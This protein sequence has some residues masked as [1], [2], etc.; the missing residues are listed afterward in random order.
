MPTKIIHRKPTSKCS[1]L[2]VKEIK[3]SIAVINVGVSSD[4]LLR[5]TFCSSRRREFSDMHTPASD[6]SQG[7]VHA[8]VAWAE[9]LAVF[10]RAW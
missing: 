1:V 5:D 7:Q 9:L 8:H 4:F 10:R 2:H 3:C 6:R